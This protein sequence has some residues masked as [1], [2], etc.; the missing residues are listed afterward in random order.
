MRLF[1]V[2]LLAGLASVCNCFPSMSGNEFTALN[3]PNRFLTQG[4]LDEFYNLVEQKFKN[5]ERRCDEG[6]TQVGTD[7]YKLANVPM[8]KKSHK[9]MCLTMGASLVKVSILMIFFISN[10][11]EIIKKDPQPIFFFRCWHEIGR[12]HV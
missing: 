8:D 4:L 12:A 7:C 5:G 1:K 11:Y 10:I 6:W 3:E 2:G 9:I